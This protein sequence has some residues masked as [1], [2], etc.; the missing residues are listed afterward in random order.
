MLRL[1][2]GVIGALVSIQQS[3]RTGDLPKAVLFG[4]ASVSVNWWETITA[5]GGTAVIAAAL[6]GGLVLLMQTGWFP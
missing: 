5:V 2:R 1:Y 4:W 3:T 6:F